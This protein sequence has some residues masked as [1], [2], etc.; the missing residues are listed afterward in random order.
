MRDARQGCLKELPQRVD[1]SR[2][3]GPKN[4]FVYPVCWTCR[5]CWC[6]LFLAAFTP[7]SRLIRSLSTFQHSRTKET[8]D[9][10]VD[11]FGGVRQDSRPAHPPRQ[12]RARSREVARVRKREGENS[13]EQRAGKKRWRSRTQM[14]KRGGNCECVMSA[15]HGALWS[16]MERYVEALCRVS[17]A[18]QFCRGFWL[19]SSDRVGGRLPS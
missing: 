13:G 11:A 2:T 8:R 17:R 10:R 16:V 14:N 9:A 7:P 5:I 15:R 4:F 12:S 3:G 18:F 19:G 6:W 1:L